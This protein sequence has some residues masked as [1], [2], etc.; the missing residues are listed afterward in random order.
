[1][2]SFLGYAPVL[3]AV[4]EY[5]ASYASNFPALIS[6]LR[7]MES[8][9]YHSGNSQWHMLHAIVLRLLR[10]EQEKVVAQL[11][12]VVPESAQIN[13]AEL[14]GPEEQ[15]SRVLGRASRNLELQEAVANIPLELVS[16]YRDVLKNAIPN[17]PF[18]A[19]CTGMPM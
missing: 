5:L 12:K 13:W 11:R 7:N 14:Y 9:P 8:D 18:W 17:H 16:R 2:S 6:E 3:E 4:A 10:R 1:M 15:C 19:K